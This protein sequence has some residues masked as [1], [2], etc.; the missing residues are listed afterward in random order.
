M[1]MLNPMFGVMLNP[2]LK[3]MFASDGA[4]DNFTVLNEANTPFVVPFIVLNEAG[5]P[6]TISNIV[7]NESN[8]PFTLS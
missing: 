2:M 7:L 6:F 8:D 4:N 3:E 1:T 5:T